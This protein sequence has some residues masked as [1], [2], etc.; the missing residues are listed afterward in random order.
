MSGRT[1]RPLAAQP[2]VAPDRSGAP[3]V[4]GRWERAVLHVDMDAFYVAVELLRRPELVGRPVVVGG[5]GDRGVVASASYEARAH[6][7]RSAMPTARARRACPNAVFLPGDH[8]R[9]REVSARV[10]AIFG[11]VTPLVEPLSLDEAFLDVTGA[12][13][14]A[15]PPEEIAARLRAEVRSAE[16]L[17]CSVGVAP[18]KFLAKLASEAAKPIA[19]RRGPR[20][21][22]GVVVVRRGEELAFLHPL[23]VEALWGVGPATLERLRGLGV[24]TVG[25]LAAL[26]ERAVVAALGDSVGRHLW[27]LAHARDDRPVEVDRP[28]RSI[29]HE[30]TFPTDVDDRAALERELVRLADA[31]G[32]RLRS[33][34]LT[35]RTVTLKVRFG[36]FRS[37]T[38]SATLPSPVD[39]G[40]VLA[41]EAKRLLAA[42]DVAPG[43]RLLGVGATGLGQ[44]RPQQLSFEDPGESWRAAEGVVDAIR[45]RFGTA[46]IRPATVVATSEERAEVAERSPWGPDER[47]ED[48]RPTKNRR[49]RSSSDRGGR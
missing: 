40:R 36:D 27:A 19:D 6:G 29:S 13:Q 30:E 32:A 21:G 1:E 44:D 4:R 3:A 24:R 20:P 37:I 8:A 41:V 5:T 38:R 9:Y 22:R 18:S 2:S 45:A 49:W 34:E 28:A 33:G 35:A 46:A 26:P 16:R 31:V 11:A 48:E 39:S 42:V 25:Q 12:Q 7:V 23:P 47:I 14:L 15:G 43:V 17:D 10:M